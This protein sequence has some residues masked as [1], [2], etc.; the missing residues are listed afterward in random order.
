[1]TGHEFLAGYPAK[2]MEYGLGALYLFLF[3]AFWRYVAGQPAVQAAMGWFTLPKGLLLSPGHTWARREHDG[4]VTVGLDE[5]ATRLLGPV[6]LA[7]L[8]KAGDQVHSGARALTARDGSRFVAFA[9]PLEGTVV[10]VNPLLTTGDWQ[11]NPYEAG[12][13][14]KVKPQGGK[15]SGLLEGKKA[16]KLL[17]DQCHQLASRL[18]PQLGHVLQ[19]GGAPVHGIA[20]ELAPETWDDLCREFIRPV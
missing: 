19:D 11:H 17:D 7:D 15:L 3:L 18:S 13:I 5:F 12:W 20:R 2:L 9:S 16:Q 4:L 10:A 14:L 1:M 8:P 6:T